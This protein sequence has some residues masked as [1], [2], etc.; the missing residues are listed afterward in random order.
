MVSNKTILDGDEL[1]CDYIYDE[2]SPYEYIP[3]WLIEPKERPGLLVKKQYVYEPPP[4]FKVL[5]KINIIKL[6]PV[7]EEYYT[8]IGKLYSNAEIEGKKESKLF[9]TEKIRPL[10]LKSN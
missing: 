3:D 4:M 2:R 1:F 7:Y 10:L 9:V 5:S 6:G 8:R